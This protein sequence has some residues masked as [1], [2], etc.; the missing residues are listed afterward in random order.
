MQEILVGLK[1]IAS[2]LG[3]GVKTVKKWIIKEGLPAQRYSDG[4]YRISKKGLL[5]WIVT[6]EESSLHSIKD[7]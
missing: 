6:K 3:T 7:G 2:V 5:Q 4:I 1:E